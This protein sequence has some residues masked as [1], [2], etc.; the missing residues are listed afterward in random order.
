MGVTGFKRTS[1]LL[2][3]L[4]PGLGATGPCQH[5]LSSS[6]SSRH[7]CLLWCVP[8]TQAPIIIYWIISSRRLS[9]HLP[10]PMHH[11]GYFSMH[12]VCGTYSVHCPPWLYN[13]ANDL[14]FNS[15]SGWGP[16]VSL[17][18]T[19]SLPTISPVPQNPLL[20]DLHC[21]F[22]VQPVFCDQLPNS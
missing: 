14:C 3:P 6:W 21:Y 20:C 11:F 16:C 10:C 5:S 15:V 17:P 4:L 13:Q 1:V 18:W 22:S 7:P 19:L 2:S 9:S 12:A 8:P